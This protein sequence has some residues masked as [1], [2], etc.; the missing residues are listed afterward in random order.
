MF[1]SELFEKNYQLL[2]LKYTNDATTTPPT[3]T[4]TTIGYVSIDSFKEANNINF[5]LTD[6]N[7][8]TNI[9]NTTTTNNNNINLTSALLTPYPSLPLT[10]KIHLLL[11]LSTE[12][13]A[14]N[15]ARSFLDEVNNKNNN[16][17]NNNNNKSNKNYS[18][19]N[20]NNN[21]NIDNNIFTNTNQKITI[22]K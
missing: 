22:I 6:N 21:N 17:D 14:T 13:L 4:T 8:N 15:I 11:L 3:T 9:S 12:F 1:L 18:N 19:I 10:Q 7:N 20:N 2:L 16:S 5:L